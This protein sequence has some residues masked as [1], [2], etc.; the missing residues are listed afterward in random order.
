MDLQASS[1]TTATL[2]AL[3]LVSVIA[4]AWALH[5]VSQP[6]PGAAVQPP[7]CTDV[8]VGTGETIQVGQVLVNVLNAGR[9]VGLAQGTLG[10]LVDLGF[11][12]G[13]RGNTHRVPADTAAQVWADDPKAPAAQLVASYLGHRVEVVRKDAGMPGITVVV[14]DGFRKVRRGLP[15][16]TAGKDTT[17]C[18]PTAPNEG[19]STPS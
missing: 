11:A 2:G 6:F 15:S 1:R 18:E 7:I 10:R 5:E 9:T 14:G 13:E 12:P 16:V 8:A 3:T 19:L 17:V 4:V